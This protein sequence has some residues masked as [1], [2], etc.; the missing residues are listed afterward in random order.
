MADGRLR[1]GSQPHGGMT[2]P[3]PGKGF[4]LVASSGPKLKLYQ[5]TACSTKA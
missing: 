3:G 5:L 4:Q 1:V 2:D